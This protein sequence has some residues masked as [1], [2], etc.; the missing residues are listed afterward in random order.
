MSDV[1][2]IEISDIFGL[3]EPITKLVESVS[4][5]IGK[6]YEPIYI[7]RMA[8]AK[9]EEI[10]IIGEAISENIALPSKYEDG[11]IIIDATEAKELLQRTRNRLVFTEMRKQQ[12][13]ESI[14]A[15]TYNEL[16]NTEKVTSEPIA[17]DWLFK[18]FNIAGEISDENMQKLWSKILAGEIK[19]PNTYTFRTLNTLKNITSYE[20]KLF[21]EISPLI[22]YNR[23]EPFLYTKNELYEKYGT[24]FSKLL[25]LEDCG[26]L[27]VKSFI[28]LSLNMKKG[29]AIYN[30]KTI[31]FID[32][33]N[34]VNIG[35][36]PLSESGKQ[37]LNIIKAENGFN[38]D[39]FLEVCRNIQK[40]NSTAEF[41]A[42]PIKKI[43]EQEIEYDESKDLLAPEFNKT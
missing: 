21:E 20:A 4:S 37:V 24:N 29:N 42:Y 3:E 8:K 34:D 36:Y 6:F 12:N 40:N 22:F 38:N 13:I 33:K 31:L 5:G 25:Q 18:F 35:V 28:S 16:E 39:Y 23:E 32:S 1:K 17:Q 26:L 15:E 9:Q 41:H 30:D 2:G 27:N 14:V 19:K 7:K 10:K 43:D 11:K